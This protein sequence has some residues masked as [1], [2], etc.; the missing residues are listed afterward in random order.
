VLATPGA[1]IG[2][3]APHATATA[4]AVGLSLERRLTAIHG[5]AVRP[6]DNHLPVELGGDMSG[7]SW[8][9]NGKTWPDPDVL[10]VRSGQRV[11][12]DMVNQSMM[13]H[14]MHLHGH[15]FQVVALNGVA[16]RGARRDT[17]L[18]PPMARVTVALD[19]DNPGRWALHCHNLY[20]M[21]AGMMT[22]MRYPDII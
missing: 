2:I 15:S 16:M 20:H 10:M 1:K 14:P 9:I 6:V 11:M 18:V 19:A 5:L 21:M 3:Y 12:I 7:Y 4:P 8:S 17:V 22:E 13:S